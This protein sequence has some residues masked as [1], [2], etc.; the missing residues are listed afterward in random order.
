MARYYDGPVSDHFDGT[1]FFD[2]H[3]SPPKSIAT[4]LRWFRG[5]TE[6]ATPALE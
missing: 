1:R 3:S 2:A 5:S 6:D 4:L